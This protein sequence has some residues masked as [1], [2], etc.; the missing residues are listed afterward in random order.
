MVRFCTFELR[1]HLRSSKEE[2]ESK[3]GMNLGRRRKTT[4]WEL[5]RLKHLAEKDDLKKSRKEGRV[6]HN[7]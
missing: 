7:D 2:D 5:W 3:L 4:A 6:N 1:V